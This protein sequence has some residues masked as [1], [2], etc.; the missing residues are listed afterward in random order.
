[1]AALEIVEKEVIARIGVLR[2]SARRLWSLTLEVAVCGDCHAD[3]AEKKIS[4]AVERRVLVAI[5][6]VSK[7]VACF[8]VSCVMLRSNP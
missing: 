1:M 8:A 6:Q 5:V 3:A 7:L 4:N 2:S